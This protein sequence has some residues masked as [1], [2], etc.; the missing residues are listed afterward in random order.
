M[1]SDD[2][3]CNSR[4]VYPGSV[5]HNS[6][7][8]L[9]LYGDDIEVDYRGYEVTV[10]NFIRLLTGMLNCCIFL[11][12]K[13]EVDGLGRVLPGT[14]RSKQLLTDDRSNILVY[15]TGH[16]GDNFLKFQDFEEICSHDIADAFG[17]M[18]EKRR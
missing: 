6:D 15:M 18:W 12:M 2:I 17:Q 7:H 1:L 3:A 5:F 14:P 4:N 13:I 10:E 16:G 9:D 8:A 11:D